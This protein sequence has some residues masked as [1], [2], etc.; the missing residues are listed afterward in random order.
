MNL[1]VPAYPSAVFDR[2]ARWCLVALFFMVP[3]TLAG[4]NIALAC[5]LLFWLLAGR[6][7][8][9]AEAVR[10]LPVAVPLLG[11]FGLVV[12]GC[13]YSDASN[14]EMTHHLLKFSKLVWIV[15][16]A[17]L[18]VRPDT[19][20]QCWRAFTLAAL[21]T[22]GFSY[23][24]IWW[25][26]SWSK[27]HNQGWGVDHTVFKD[28]ISQGAVMALLMV[29]GLHQGWLATVPWRRWAWWTI[30]A[31]AFVCN[32]QL[33]MG[34]TGYLATGV[35]LLVFVLA[36]VPRRR[37]L[38]AL[39]A[40]VVV[41][42]ISVATSPQLQQRAVLA[43]SELNDHK[44]GTLSSIGQRMYFLTRS[45]ELI[46]ERPVWGWGTG[47]Y[48][49]QYCRVAT[50]AEWCAAGQFHP[51][52]QFLFF[53]VQYGALGLLLFLAVFVQAARAGRT[54]PTPS[55]ALLWSYLAILAVGS[56][57]HSS[58]WLSSESFFYAFALA[59]VVT[60]KPQRL[61]TAPV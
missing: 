17:T 36:V 44:T 34:R 2:L 6:W 16:A 11:L 23:L 38:P 18:L 3:I 22:L 14:K 24:N 45:V 8:E 42:G 51:H 1:A 7:R 25:N 27:T 41:A 37:W 50:T 28:Y 32:T 19:H 35:A 9:R 48:H 13:L 4:A 59:L 55:R 30:A 52:N 53:G 21:I 58:L 46:A 49:S 33:S 47:A 12:L 31:L 54:W 39:A 29:R 60:L 10:N 26:P 40:L 56:M 5:T 57:T 61:T 43:V 15:M 20:A